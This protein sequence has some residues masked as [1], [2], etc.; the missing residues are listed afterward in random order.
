MDYG[1][2]QEVGVGESAELVENAEGQEV[3][4][5]ILG[6]ADVIACI[7]RHACVPQ[8]IVN[9]EAPRP[10]CV[11]ESLF[12]LLRR[13]ESLGQVL[14]GPP[15]RKLS[16]ILTLQAF[17]L[18]LQPFAALQILD[19]WRIRVTDPYLLV[20]LHLNL[21]KTEFYPIFN[22]RCPSPGQ[23]LMSSSNYSI[24]GL[25]LTRKEP[26]SLLAT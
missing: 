14:G 7:L 18:E 2:Q 4:R 1:A 21:I 17:C 22:S 20:H 23:W 26:K 9:K 5:V 19:L 24:N 16:K 6:R 3:K 13:V 11:F 25:L 12:R 8:R 10:T 15:C